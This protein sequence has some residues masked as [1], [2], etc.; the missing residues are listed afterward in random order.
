MPDQNSKRSQIN[1]ILTAE[2]LQVGQRT[3]QPV[4]RA[5]GWYVAG[6]ETGRGA[7]GWVRLA[8]LD[9]VVQESDGSQRRIP[10]TDPSAQVL[11]QA[12]RSMAL[13]AAVC[14]AISAIVTVARS[15]RN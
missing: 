11:R 2:P 6:G 10:L 14:L 3:V 1:R 12:F 13:V 9:V 4:A 15:P 8:P 7:F 5:S